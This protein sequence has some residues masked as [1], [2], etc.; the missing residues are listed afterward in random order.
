M[1]APQPPD[2]GRRDN[3]LPSSEWGALVDLDPRLSE[4]LLD[5]LA[6]EGVAAY[7]EPA[8][9]VE[10]WT[11]A[12]VLPKRPLDRLWVNPALADL[13]RGVVTSEVA[14]LTALLAELE[15]GAT[16]HGLVRPVP[17]SAAVRVLPPPELPDGPAPELPPEPSLPTGSTSPVV[18]PVAGDPL[19]SD[20]ELFRQ[21]VAGYADE[22]AD[23]VPRWP[24]SEDLDGPPPA[25][26]AAA[27]PPRRRRTDRD[28]DPLPGWVEPAPLEDDGHYVPPPPPKLPRPKLRTVGAVLMVLVGFAVLFAPYEIGLDDSVLSILLGLLLAGGGAALLVAW[29]RDAPP[30]DSGPDDG[31]VV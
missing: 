13:A 23:P 5:S 4:A 2:G 8:R 29:M 1:T 7:V 26:P 11:R 10:S 30:T 20:D 27:P 19:P 15:P 21:I 18:P 9:D 24:V 22:A 25:R 12:T 31:A 6:A 17:R 28:A 3:G 16:A 14:D